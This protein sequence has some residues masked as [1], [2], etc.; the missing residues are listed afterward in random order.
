MSLQIFC[1]R[2]QWQW[3]IRGPLH[4]IYMPS[5]AVSGKGKVHICFHISWSV[6]LSPAIFI[7]FQLKQGNQPEK[8][9]PKRSTVRSFGNLEL[10]PNTPWKWLDRKMKTFSSWS[11]PS[12]CPRNLAGKLVLS[13]VLSSSREAPKFSKQWGSLLLKLLLNKSMAWREF[14]LQTIAEISPY[15]NSCLRWIYLFVF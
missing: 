10:S 6:E 13:W 9:F 4:V 3:R 11:A 5:A 1:L 12:L 14:R 8:F 15:L 2:D 7:A